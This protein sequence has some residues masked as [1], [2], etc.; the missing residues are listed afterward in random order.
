MDTVSDEQL[1]NVEN[2]ITLKMMEKGLFTHIDSTNEKAELD[3]RG[4]NKQKRTDLRQFGLAQV[5]TKEFLIPVFS[6]IL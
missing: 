3:Q 6:E 2:A 5:V 4:R 1:E